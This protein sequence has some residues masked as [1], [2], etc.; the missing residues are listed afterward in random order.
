[1]VWVRFG[2]EDGGRAFF[3]FGGVC[4]KG[5]ELWRSRS[6]G[7]DYCCSIAGAA[8]GRISKCPSEPY[9]GFY[10]STVNGDV[11]HVQKLPDA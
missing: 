8:L 11:R 7:V 1:M 4:L 6:G 5:R 9:A 3:P 2:W 10:T